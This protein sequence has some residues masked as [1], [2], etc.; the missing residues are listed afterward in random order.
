MTVS[1]LKSLEELT[2]LFAKYEQP[3]TEEQGQEVIRLIQGIESALEQ[4]KSTSTNGDPF[5]EAAI[6]QVT[7]PDKK[8]ST[9]FVDWMDPFNQ[10]KEQVETLLLQAIAYAP[11]CQSQKLEHL[12]QRRGIVRAMK[13]LAEAMQKIPAFAQA[14]QLR[15]RPDYLR[16][17][18]SPE[19]EKP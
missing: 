13:Q 7:S 1:Y 2:V 10:A 16:M 6:A 4:L 11:H 18:P 19:T 3:L 8:R 14:A 5:F 15:E 9:M 17:V 12:Q